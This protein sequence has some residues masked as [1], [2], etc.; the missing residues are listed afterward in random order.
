MFV[1]TRITETINGPRKTY[2][3]ER[4][5]WLLTHLIENDGDHKPARFKTKKKAKAAA[6]PGNFGGRVVLVEDEAGLS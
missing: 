3:T 2:L 6:V 1:L 4:G 5:A